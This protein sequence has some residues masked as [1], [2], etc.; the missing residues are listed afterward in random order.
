MPYLIYLRK[1]RADA[2]AEARGEGETLARHEAQL[3][4]L[5]KKKSLTVGG[6]YREIVSGDTIAARPQ[7]QK[8]IG[9]VS[10]GAWEGVIV[11]EIERLARGDTIDQGIVA[12]TFTYSGTK[13]ITPSKTYD[14]RS[15]ADQEYFEFSLFMSR[16]EYK[17]INRRMQAGRIASLKEGNY[18]ATFAPYGY[19]KI[20][21][22]EKR[23]FTLEIVP[24]EAELIRLMFEKSA[25]NYGFAKIAAMLNDMGVKPKRG[26]QWTASGVQGIVTNPVYC[27][28][29]R[30]NWRKQKKQVVDGR[31]VVSRPKSSDEECMIIQGNHPPIITEEQ[32]R[33][34]QNV[35][36]SRKNPHTSFTKPLQNPFAHL[37]YCG[38]CDHAMVRR[39]YPDREAAM[40]CVYSACPCKSSDISQIELLIMTALNDGYNKYMAM[41]KNGDNSESQNENELAVLNAEIKKAEKQQSK[42]YDLLEQEIYTPEVFTER[43]AILTDKLTKLKER[44][45]Q[46]DRKKPMKLTPLEAALAIKNVIDGYGDCKNAPEKNELL[47]TVCERITYVKQI[48]G[49]WNTSDAVCTIEYNF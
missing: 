1:S 43:N 19:K 37:L 11:M 6:I 42:L 25:G 32:F 35:I 49:R 15:E 4:E 26:M 33:L 24:E 2:E 36:L 27:G 20:R 23:S 7:M 12:Q 16:R 41:A 18:I 46:L 29:M 44:L 21:D 14:P 5:A 47:K 40:L 45:Q 30:W 48:G 34:S 28:K 17:T 31:V 9:E 22:Y 10:A 38:L 39:P 8:L 13:I 3:I